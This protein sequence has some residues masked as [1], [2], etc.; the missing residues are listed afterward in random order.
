M[1]TRK[2]AEAIFNELGIKAAPKDD[3]IY[4]EAPSVRFINRSTKSMATGKED[5][6]SNRVTKPQP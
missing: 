5:S 2:E 6:T 3:P 4:N 1:I